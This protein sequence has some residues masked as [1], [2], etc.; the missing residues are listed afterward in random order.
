MET[1]E[2]ESL[3]VQSRRFARWP[4][5]TSRYKAQRAG[6]SSRQCKP[7]LI[8][9]ACLLSLVVKFGADFLDSLEGDL[10]KGKASS[11]PDAFPV[12]GSD[13]SRGRLCSARDFQDAGFC[14]RSLPQTL[15]Y[16]KVCAGQVRARRRFWRS[17]WFAFFAA[18]V[19]DVAGEALWVF[20]CLLGYVAFACIDK[21]AF[22]GVYLGEGDEMRDLPFLL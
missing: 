1:A 21:P 17:F 5:K 13:G 16:S 18:L 9:F 3:S 20:R 2:E 11:A 12:L 22:G 8:L 6:R 15:C 4:L 7:G 19:C 14:G 10:P